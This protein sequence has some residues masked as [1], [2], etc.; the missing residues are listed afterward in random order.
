MTPTQ[1][2]ARALGDPT[3]YAIFRYLLDAGRR[4]DIAE[5][6]AHLGRHHSGIRQHLAHLVDAELVD[7]APAPPAGRGRPRLTYA[8]AP[9][10]EGRWGATDPYEQLSLVLAEAI[11]T[12]DP[13]V[14][15]GRRS[16]PVTATASH[17]DPVDQI[18]DVIRHNGFDPTV[19]R[20]GRRVEVTLRRCPFETAAAA[21]PATV[22][23]VHLGMA[24]GAADRSDGRVVVEQLV[25]RDPHRAGCRLR[26]RVQDGDDG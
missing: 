13:L 3:R 14:E 18:V 8:V 23:T 16:V 26:L 17:D 25:P 6:T 10:T 22:C 11:R 5:L 1:T 4:V 21:D 7:E 19:S 12:G 2:E 24:Q 20:R 9:T 15:V